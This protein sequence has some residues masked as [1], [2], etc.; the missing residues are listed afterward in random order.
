MSEA[1][2]KK[3]LDLKKILTEEFEF[4][5]KMFFAPVTAIVHEVKARWKDV[6]AEV[7]KAAPKR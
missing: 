4:S 1:T 6:D 3:Q 7:E 5:F 2:E